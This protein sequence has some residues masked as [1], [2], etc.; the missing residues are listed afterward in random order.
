MSY[1]HA[2]GFEPKTFDRFSFTVTIS[3]LC[4]CQ[5][6]RFFLFLKRTQVDVI[7]KIIL[8]GIWGADPYMP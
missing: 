8:G 6:V 4:S 7:G 2:K 5:I 3:L 1:Q